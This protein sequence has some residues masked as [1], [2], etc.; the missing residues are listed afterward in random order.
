MVVIGDSDE[1]KMISAFLR[2]EIDSPRF[3]QQIAT[4]LALL[5][6]SREIIDNPDF[7][8][9]MQN[10][11][12]AQLLNFRGYST[13]TYLFSGFPVNVI[14][15]HIQLGYDELSKLKYANY[16]TWI[17]LSAGSRLVIDGA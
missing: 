1:N 3:G 13:R 2:A 4:D 7:N 8:D 5:G 12:R 6:Y 16:R 14:W 11:V 15:Q 9:K 10:I 17:Q